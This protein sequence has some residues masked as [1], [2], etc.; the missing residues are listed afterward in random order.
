MTKKEIKDQMRIKNQECRELLRR[1]VVS[2]DAEELKKID[3]L[4]TKLHSELDE[5][6]ASLDE[7]LENDEAEESS[8]RAGTFSYMDTTQTRTFNLNS[9][10][11]KNTCN[12]DGVTLRNGESM[13]SRISDDSQKNLDLGKYV[14]GAVT[15]VWTD[16]TEERNAF[17]TTANGVI[18]PQFLSAHIIDR[19]RNTSLFGSSGVPIVPMDTNNMT[20]ARVESDPT[21]SFKKELS[22]S[23]AADLTLESVELKSKTAYGYAYVSLEAIHSANNLSEILYQVF[24]QAMADCI[25]KG[26]LYGQNDDD[27]APSGIM[28]DDGIN[29]IVATN[30]RYNDFIKGISAIKRA[31]GNPSVI[32]INAAT[33]EYLSLLCDD[34]GKYLDEPKPFTELTKIISNQL[35][36]DDTGSDALIFDPNAMIIGMQKNIIFRMFQDTDYCIKNG[37]VGFQIYSMLD[38]VA[39]QPSHITKITGIKESE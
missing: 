20:I 4:V 14:R 12:G 3:E 34:T 21:F 2:Q 29:H 23:N 31:N 18:I 33:D 10:L 19:A 22:E 39:T 36:C 35:E 30:V 37:A 13:I 32:G 9:N 5:L 25:D 26:M 27:F 7:L 1:A 11:N 8:K 38:C 16:A 17:S 24:S 28:N 15:G 6:E